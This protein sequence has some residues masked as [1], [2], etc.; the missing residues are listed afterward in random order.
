M[1]NPYRYRGYRYDT[2]TGLYYLNSRYYNPEWGRFINADALAGQV[3]ELLSHNVFAYCQNNVANM[4]DPSGFMMVCITDGCGGSSKPSN[5]KNI[6]LKAAIAGSIAACDKIFEKVANRFIKTGKKLSVLDGS[7]T[8]FG[9]AF[10]AYEYIEKNPIGAGIKKISKGAGLVTAA[11]CGATVTKDLI[12][13]EGF[14]AVIDIASF[15]AGI[16]VGIGT[17]FVAGLFITAS[18]PVLAAGAIG[19]GAIA[20]SVVI[21]IGID[22][23]A[24]R[25]K[26]YYYKR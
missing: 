18:T 14:S 25:A 19:V 20:A 10:E 9:K 21:G 22:Y 6:G 1:K 2:E 11:Y 12:K 3:G 8:E 7:E 5:K 24:D 17:S 23:V 26:D 15:A 4:G 13:G 16:G